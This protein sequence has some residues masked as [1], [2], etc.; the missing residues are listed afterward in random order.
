M[1]AIDSRCAS[2][3]T[4]RIAAPAPRLLAVLALLANATALGAALPCVPYPMTQTAPA[5]LACPPAYVTA[6]PKS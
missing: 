5:P 2:S 3:R 6:P 1:Q 4:P